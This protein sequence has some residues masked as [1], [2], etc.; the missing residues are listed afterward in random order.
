VR[1]SASREY[2][3]RYAEATLFGHLASHPCLAG[4]ARCR[5]HLLRLMDHEVM[6]P[7]GN[8]LALNEGRYRTAMVQCLAD[9]LANV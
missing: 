4:R 2:H 6:S 7:M 9:L 3:W 8:R 5:A 1:Q